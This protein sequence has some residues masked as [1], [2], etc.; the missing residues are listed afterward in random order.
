LGAGI[1]VGSA[2][3]GAQAHIRYLQNSGWL[4]RTATHVLVFDCVEALPQIDP[5]PAGVALEAKDLDKPSV[6]VF[7]THGHSDHYSRTVA[8]WSKERPDIQ[9]VLGWPDAYLSGAHVMTPRQQWS[10]GA[11]VHLTAGLPRP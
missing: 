1:A 3:A 8:Q 7:V 10:S 2:P 11:L 9:Y 5:L 6:V 4:V